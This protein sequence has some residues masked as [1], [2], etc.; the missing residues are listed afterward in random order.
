MSNANPTVTHEHAYHV[1]PTSTFLWVWV[2]LLVLTTITAGASILFPG[3][4][5]ILVAMVVTPAKATLILMYF[6]HLK[7]EKKVFVIMFLTA[8]G[9]FAIFLGL[10]FFDYLFR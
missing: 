5:G 1:I 9:I 6:M 3:T 8:M 7:Y 2:A 10:T 4:V